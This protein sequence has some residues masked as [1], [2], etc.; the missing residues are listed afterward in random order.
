[1]SVEP[2]LIEKSMIRTTT[3]Q[4][5]PSILQ[6]RNTKDEAEEGEIEEEEEI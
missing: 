3:S 2:H 4:P 5:C 6:L 1:M